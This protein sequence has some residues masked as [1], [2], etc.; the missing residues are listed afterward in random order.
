MKKEKMTP[1]DLRMRG[2][3][4]ALGGKYA[5]VSLLGWIRFSG[6]VGY[7]IKTV[8]MRSY[9]FRI[10]LQCTKGVQLL[11]KKKPSCRKGF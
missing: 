11:Q 3:L 6:L 5:S 9:R 7:W 4:I 1:S 2:T 8:V 10:H